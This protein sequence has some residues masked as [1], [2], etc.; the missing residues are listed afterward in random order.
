MLAP[1]NGQVSQTFPGRGGTVVTINMAGN[2]VSG[3]VNW[4]AQSGDKTLS[5]SFSATISGNS[6]TTTTMSRADFK[7]GIGPSESLC[8]LTLTKAG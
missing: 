2:R 6:V 7:G 4:R 8:T 1:T 3:T 5:G